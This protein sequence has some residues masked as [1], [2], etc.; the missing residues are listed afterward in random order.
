MDLF[1]PNRLEGWR[2]V[3]T[4]R[5]G[6]PFNV[7]GRLFEGLQDRLSERLADTFRASRAACMRPERGPDVVEMRSAEMKQAI[8]LRLCRWAGQDSNPRH[9]G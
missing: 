5:S 8:Y 2:G 1:K 4:P 7:C 9:E 6:R 3:A